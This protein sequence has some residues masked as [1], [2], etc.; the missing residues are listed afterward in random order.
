[1]AKKT[2][3][4]DGFEGFSS[5]GLNFLRDLKKNNEREWFQERRE[6]YET[7]LK[8]PVAKLTVAVAEE[9]AAHKLKLTGD[10]KTSLFRL[11]RDVRFSRDKSPYKT[12][13]GVVFSSDGRK[14]TNGLLY[15]HIDPA[16]SFWA[17]GFYYPE[18][19]ALDALRQRIAGK[20][21]QMRD[22]LKKLSRVG[23]ELADDNTA[24]K[25]LPRGFEK[26]EDEDIQELVRQ[27][28]YIVVRDMDKSLLKKPEALIEETIQFAKD[29][30]PLL[31]FGWSALA[32][33][34][35]QK[36]PDFEWD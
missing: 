29:S 27:K 8:L 7:E 30:Y 31:E 15:V 22:T 24:L 34:P 28:S 12:H 18:Q 1:V 16:R 3:T 14:N 25:R 17:T 5:K 33:K 6:I 13:L 4:L 32:V 26:V 11:N 2:V 9:L 20:P 10:P 19:A 23:L 35:K 36:R 21:Q